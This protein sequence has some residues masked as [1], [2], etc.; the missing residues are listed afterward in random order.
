[1]MASL[2]MTR[3]YIEEYGYEKYKLAEIYIEDFYK[4]IS[5]LNWLKIPDYP[6]VYD[7]DFTRIILET[8]VPA[9][10]VV[11][12]LEENNIYIEMISKNI[13]VL[14]VSIADS[15]N[16]FIYLADILLKYN[17][18]KNHN[19]DILTEKKYSTINENILPLEKCEGKILRENIIIYPPGSYYLKIGDKIAKENIEYIKDLINSGIN[20]YTDFNK[21]IYNLYVSSLKK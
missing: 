20:V 1:M 17:P 13:L 19:I 21:D 3:A 10:S 15:E 11:K 14:I 12:Y 6:M 16:D 8:T 7:K 2:D 5:T 9:I 4:K 18:N